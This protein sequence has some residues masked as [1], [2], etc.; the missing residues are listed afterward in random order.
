MHVVEG[1]RERLTCL[2]CEAKGGRFAPSWAQPES[3]V[4]SF[5]A[6]NHF[7]LEVITF[8]TDMHA[9]ASVFG[10]DVES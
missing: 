10:E 3:L 8:R 6:Q 2:S 4:F 7:L 9:D 5:V 1:G